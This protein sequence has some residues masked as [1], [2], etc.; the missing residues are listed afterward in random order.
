MEF[1]DLTYL[2][3]L[4]LAFA[5]GTNDVSKAIATLVGSGVT[6]YRT[7]IAWGTFWTM[8]GA[9]AAVYVATAM[10][11]TFGSGYIQPGLAI[12][13][14]LAPA[15][16][17]GAI[18][19][20][21]F[22]S[23]F[24]L[25]VSTTHALTG[26]LVGAGLL[27]FGTDG[28]IWATVAKKIALPLLLSPFLSLALSFLVHPLIGST[29]RRWEGICVCI[30]PS[31]RALV[32]INAQ[33]RTRTLFQA[34]G[35]GVP[36]TAVPSQCD[37]AGLTGTTVG[38]D[39]IHWL[40]SGLASLARGTNDAPKIAAMLLLGST[41]ASPSEDLHVIAFGGVT[42][43]MGIGSY[44]GGRRVTEVLAEKVTKMNHAEGLSANL[45]T[46]SLV[47]LS[48]IFGLP[49]STTHISSS[50]IIGI[51]LLKGAAEVRW[52][53]VRDMVFAW[54]VTLPIA[55]FLACLAYLVLI[56]AVAL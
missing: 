4:V 22:A 28:L 39:S 50:A 14:V 43:A 53:T 47:L 42:V 35:M 30:M 55:A 44:W 27:A 25:P 21:L 19:W 37:R 17:I 52:T 12:P 8:V 10:V 46:S 15:I 26:S 49:V 18:L 2:L 33:G 9:S 6:D 38:L 5:N 51:G 48:G 13:S 34:R 3:I 24:G 41:T 45:T 11:K 7:A 32:T 36:V 40:S 20:I 29:A 23:T 31:H 16:L 1:S 54:I 56:R